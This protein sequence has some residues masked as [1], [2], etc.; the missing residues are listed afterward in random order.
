MQLEGHLAKKRHDTAAQILDF[1]IASDLSAGK[2]ERPAVWL[3]GPRGW[4]KAR[5]LS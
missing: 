1:L 4:V 5:S 3:P 2:T